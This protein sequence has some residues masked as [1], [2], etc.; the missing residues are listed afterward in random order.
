M[1]YL[2]EDRISA[3]EFLSSLSEGVSPSGDYPFVTQ[4]L[5]TYLR[6]VAEIEDRWNLAKPDSSKVDTEVIIRYQKCPGC[7]KKLHR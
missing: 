7:I 6:A 5:G 2:F 1:I 4:N 3:T